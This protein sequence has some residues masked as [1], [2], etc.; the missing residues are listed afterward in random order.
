[1][2]ALGRVYKPPSEFTTTV[3]PLRESRTRCDFI[4]YQPASE[5]QSTLFSQNE[6]VC[7]LT[8]FHQERMKMQQRGERARGE[9]RRKAERGAALTL[10]RH[11]GAARQAGGQMCG[12]LMCHRARDKQS[13]GAK[14]SRELARHMLIYLPERQIKGRTQ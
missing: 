1:M 2:L 6:R 9:E 13:K 11:G 3:S 12:L 10:T 4:I 14:E 8:Q 7:C 5:Q